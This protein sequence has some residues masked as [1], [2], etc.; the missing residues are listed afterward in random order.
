MKFKNEYY[1][2]L[3]VGFK[4]RSIP[5]SVQGQY[6]HR[7]TINVKIKAYVFT[8]KDVEDIEK[9]EL[10]EGMDLV[11]NLTDVS[12]KELYEDID[13][14][15][16][17]A[18]EEGKE[19]DVK[20][21]EFKLP[22]GNIFEGFQEGVVGPA[23]GAAKEFVR[24]FKPSKVLSSDYAEDAVKKAATDKAVGQCVLIYDIFKKGHRMVTW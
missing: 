22:F 5:T 1:S 13:H 23:K 8:E 24:V 6:L 15:I 19:K 10:F 4:Y 17:E 14:Y 20:K 9:Q 21:K 12:L 7:G 16:T 18:K 3:D 2:C 11:D